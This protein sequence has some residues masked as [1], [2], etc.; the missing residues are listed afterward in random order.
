MSLPSRTMGIF[1]FIFILF[2]IFH[3]LK[4]CMH[5]ISDQKN[6][7]DGHLFECQNPMKFIQQIFSCR[8]RDRSK[9]RSLRKPFKGAWEQSK[10]LPGS[11]EIFVKCLVRGLEKGLRKE[12]RR[13]SQRGENKLPPW[14]RGIRQCSWRNW[15]TLAPRKDK[16]VE[17]KKEAIASLC[18]SAHI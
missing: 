16:R 9:S 7:I 15:L 10:R 18:L 17:G 11:Q 13:G 5:Y 6:K 1:N 2:C 14:Q 3:I 8:T 4:D 12:K